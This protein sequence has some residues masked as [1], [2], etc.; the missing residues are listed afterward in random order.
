MIA[1]LYL[2]LVN[3]LGFGLMRADKRRA[4]Q[5]AWRIP[6]ATLLLPAIAG[7][8]PGTWLGMYL[9]H[10]KT[11]KP[12]FSVTVPILALVQTAAVWYFL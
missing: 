2:L 9:F 7:G 5:K 12:K 6:E 10:H 1:A 3:A 11:R 4:R 8:A